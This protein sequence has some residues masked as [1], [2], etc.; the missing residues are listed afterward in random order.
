MAV[1][2]TNPKLGE[3]SADDIF[4]AQLRKL[5]IS[6][7]AE[8]K[9]LIAIAGK[10]GFIVQYDEK[11]GDVS[12][13]VDDTNL[14]P[15]KVQ[16]AN[17]DVKKLAEAISPYIMN[18]INVAVK[19]NP[20]HVDSTAL[21]ANNKVIMKDLEGKLNRGFEVMREKLL[22]SSYSGNTS[23]NKPVK[24][25]GGGNGYKVEGSQFGVVPNHTIRTTEK[26]VKLPR[27][28]AFWNHVYEDV[29][30]SWWKYGAFVVSICC[31]IFAL[32]IWYQNYRLE[33]VVKEYY[34]IKPVLK[35]DPHY[36]PFIQTLDSAILSSG[37]DEV[38]KKI[39]R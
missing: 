31:V 29:I 25:F 30:S 2:N 14:R 39:Y 34:I 15:E 10:L 9:V 24:R 8:V 37:V 6:N 32:T 4:R 5:N 3:S 18:A 27:L 7:D 11:T 12:M 33:Q 16:E 23:E 21:I 20:A 19:K 38:C 13:K 35:M 26:E 36:S 17:V 1:K 22:E 28:K